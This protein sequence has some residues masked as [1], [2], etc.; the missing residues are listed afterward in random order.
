MVQVSEKKAVDC[1]LRGHET[2][3]EMVP[4]GRGLIGGP[5]RI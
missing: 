2:G 3:L 5:G 1:R 4:D